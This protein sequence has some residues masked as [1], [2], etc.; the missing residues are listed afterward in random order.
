MVI[1]ILTLWLY[2]FWHYG[3]TDFDII[4]IQSLTLWLYRFW[5]YGYTDFDTMVIQILTLWLYRFWHY[6]YADFNTMISDF[7]MV[8][9]ILNYLQLMELHA[10]EN[11]IESATNMQ[12]KKILPW[13]IVIFLRNFVSLT[14]MYKNC[15]LEKPSVVS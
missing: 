7:D 8:I 14:L 10:L 13:K 1:Q 3:Y 4:V 15:M 5:H 11:I 9:Q 2:R 6:G 12:I